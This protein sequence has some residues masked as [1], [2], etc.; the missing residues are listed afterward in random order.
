MHYLAQ[1]L[2]EVLQWWENLT[3]SF[4]DRK[5]LSSGAGQFPVRMQYFVNN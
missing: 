5:E 1:E 3:K 4:P 2:L